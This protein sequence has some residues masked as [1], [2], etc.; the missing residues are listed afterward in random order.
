MIFAIV[1]LLLLVLV[2]GWRCRKLVAD[3]RILEQ[4]AKNRTKDLLRKNRQLEKAEQQICILKK[5]GIKLE[6]IGQAKSRF[7][8][9]VCH[10]F[11][12]PLTL[13][14]GT[15]EQILDPRGDRLEENVRMMSRNSQRLLHLVNQCSY[16]LTITVVNLKPDMGILMKMILNNCLFI[17]RIRGILY[18]TTLDNRCNLILGSNHNDSII[19]EIIV[20]IQIFE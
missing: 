18:Q 11:R 16:F 20:N 17:K 4:T 19:H 15:L 5:Q 8:A 10:E 6:E 2:I 3:I 1:F 14:M 9:D 7:F 13:I 12:T